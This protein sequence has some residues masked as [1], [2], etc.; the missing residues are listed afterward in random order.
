MVVVSLS[1][2]K[3][4]TQD[5]K[6]RRL[7]IPLASSILEVDTAAAVALCWESILVVVAIVVAPLWQREDKNCTGILKE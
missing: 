5:E 7:G 3:M 1:A 6:E 2:D 4:G